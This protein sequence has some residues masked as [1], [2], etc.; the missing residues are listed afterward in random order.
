[1]IAM[2]QLFVMVKPIAQF[3]VSIATF[4]SKVLRGFLGDS[5]DAQRCE[6]KSKFQLF[7]NHWLRGIDSMPLPQRVSLQGFLKDS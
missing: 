4:R 7:V 1:M 5:S 2:F 3:D 6:W